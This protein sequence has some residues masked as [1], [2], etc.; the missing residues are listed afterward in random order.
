MN[1]VA[2]TV[3]PGMTVIDIGAHIGYYNI[4]LREVCRSKR[5]RGRI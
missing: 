1:V 4:V 2:A 3:R 5:P